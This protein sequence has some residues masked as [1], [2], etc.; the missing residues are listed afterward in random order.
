M[1]EDAPAWAYERAELRPYDPRWAVRAAAECERLGDLLAPWLLSGV[2][3]IGSTAVPGLAAKPVIDLMASVAD[4][5]TAVGRA[6]ERLAADGWCL[7]PPDLDRRSWRRF[8]VKPDPSGRRRQA[9][10]HLI[11]A[12]H[13]RWAEQ[14]RFR[15]ALRRDRRLAQ[16]YADLKRRL[17]ERH[18]HD[19]EAYTAAKAEFV[20]SVLAEHGRPGTP[21]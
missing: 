18:G 13:P 3:H 5:D 21:R 10:L 8:F 14:V 11:R 20:A 2:V 4:L 15:D 19:R 7:V 17:A 6:S 12:G 9:H 1:S 16:R